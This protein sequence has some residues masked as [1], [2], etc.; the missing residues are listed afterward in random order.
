MG[1]M[2]RENQPNIE[3]GLTVTVLSTNDR[4]YKKNLIFFMSDEYGFTLQSMHVYN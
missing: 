4:K 1:A 3:C 2:D